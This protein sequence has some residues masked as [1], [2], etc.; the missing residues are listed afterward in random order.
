MVKTKVSINWY[1]GQVRPQFSDC[2]DHRIKESTPPFVW[3]LHFTQRNWCA[4]AVDF[5]SLG[6]KGLEPPR[7]GTFYPVF[8]DTTQE[9]APGSTLEEIRE[10][11]CL[12]CYYNGK[13]TLKSTRTRDFICGSKKQ[14]AVQTE[15]FGYNS[16]L[17]EGGW[18][19]HFSLHTAFSQQC[20]TFSWISARLSALSSY[21]T[22]LLLAGSVGHRIELKGD[23][24]HI[25][26]GFRSCS[27]LDNPSLPFEKPS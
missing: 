16:F 12:S 10:R 21:C 26:C 8:T 3:L 5:N 4:L 23:K 14:E 6:R 27:I 18:I 9:C 24:V 13:L 25:R 17:L 15:A 2:P 11:L 7:L 20:Q 19:V 22:H 1:W